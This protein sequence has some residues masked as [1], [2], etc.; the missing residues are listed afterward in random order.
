MYMR[1]VS[2]DIPDDMIISYK[3]KTNNEEKDANIVVV[4]NDYINDVT[5]TIDKENI[6]SVY[7]NNNRYYIKALAKGTCRVTFYC[8]TAITSCDVTVV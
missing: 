7:K 8:S 5:W 2:S 3:I 4:P 6:V 1:C